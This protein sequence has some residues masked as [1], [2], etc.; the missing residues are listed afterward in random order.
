MENIYR[1]IFTTNGGYIMIKR[2]IQKGLCVGEAHDM[3]IAYKKSKGI[4]E[5]SIE[6]FKGAYALLLKD[7]SISEDTPIS[8]ITSEIIYKWVTYLLEERNN[9]VTS[10]N[11]Y[12]GH[13]RVFLYWCMNSGYIPKYKINLLKHQEEMVKYYSDEELEIIIKKPDSNC[14]YS[15][16]RTWVIICLILS[17]GARVSTV[18]NIKIKDVNFSSNELTYTHLKNKKTAIIPLSNSISNILREYLNIWDLQGDYLF[19]SV[20]GNKLTT[21]ALAQALS[22]YCKRRGVK[23][24]GPHALRHSFARSWIRNG[25]GAF[26]LQQMLTHSDLTMTKKYVRLFSDDLH[27]DIKLY[28]PLDNLRKSKSRAHNITRK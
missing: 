11:A 5:A 25:G 17:T 21:S 12:L 13:L 26:Q 3:F 9:R 19:C 18:C 10:V 7:M 22:K 15:E 6:C 1:E 14:Q 28:S 16:Y 2:K 20:S 27:E 24:L 8:C 23:S 4:S